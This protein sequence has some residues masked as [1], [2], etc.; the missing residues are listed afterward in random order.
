M[1]IQYRILT[2]ILAILMSVSLFACDNSTEKTSSS[3]D[4]KLLKI[5]IIQIAPHSSLD[6]CYE[7][8]V[9]GLK[10]KGFVHGKNITID[11]Q[12][13][14][15]DMANSDLFAKNM[16]SSKYDMIIGIATPSAMSAYSFAKDTSIPVVFAAVSDPVAAG[17]VKSMENPEYN[18]TGTSDLLPLEPQMKMIRAFLPE[19]KKIGIIY[20]TSEPNS[21]SHL[22]ALEKLAPDYGFEIKAIGV[23]NASEV[24]SAATTLVSQGVDCINNFTDNNV[25]DNLTT[26]LNAANEGNIPV[27]GSEIEQVKKGCLGSVGLDYLYLGKETG[28]IAA[29]ILS[30]EAKAFDI[31][32]KIISDSEPVY[33]KEVLDKLGLTLPEEYKETKNVAE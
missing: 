30:G 28:K 19:G 21:V 13:A 17:I 16:V 3:N 14:Q 1:K 31:P 4:V 12:N 15:G 20:T 6:N 11:Y 24:G 26:V 23:T 22:E 32:V 10:E 5:G 27:F 8:L 25:V 7:G 9:E 33:N 29:L 18:V 2:V